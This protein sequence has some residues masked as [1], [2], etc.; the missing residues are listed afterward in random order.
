MGIDQLN[1]VFSFRLTGGQPVSRFFSLGI[2]VGKKPACA[3]NTPTTAQ[4]EG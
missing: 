4:E 1:T 2:G 3:N